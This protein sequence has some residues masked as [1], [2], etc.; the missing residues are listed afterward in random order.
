MAKRL[1][2]LFVYAIIIVVVKADGLSDFSNNLAS[3]LGPLLSLFGDAVTRQYLSESTKLIDYFIFAMAPIGIISTI[4]AVIRVCGSPSL[5]AFIGK[6][7]EGEATAE[8]E[9]CTST[10]SDVCELFNKGGIT[11]VLGRPDIIELVYVPGADGSDKS[12]PRLQL[13]TRYLE[14]NLDDSCWVKCQNESDSFRS[15]NADVDSINR[16][17]FAP[18][19]NLS[20]NVGIKR[21]PDSVFYIVAAIGFILQVGIIIFAAITAWP[22]G[23]NAQKLG[24]KASQNYAPGIYIVGTI[25]LCFG[26]W[27][28]AALIG[29]TTNEEYYERKDES[30]VLYWVQPGPQ[31]IGDQTFDS[32]AYSDADENRR[33][34]IWVSSVKDFDKTFQTPTFFAVL[35]VLLGYVAQ[36]IGLRGLDAWI[37]IAQLAITLIMSVLRGALRMRRLDKSDNRLQRWGNLVTGHELDWLAFEI[38]DKLSQ[39]RFWCLT[40][41]HDNAKTNGCIEENDDVLQNR[42]LLSNITGHSPF[43]SMEAKGFQ[44]W[45]DKRVKVRSKAKYL[46]EAISQAA[47]IL[48][49]DQR[50]KET[51]QLRVKVIVADTTPNWSKQ[52]VSIM[53]KPPTGPGQ[54][55]WTVD[56]SQLEAVLGL[57]LWS[58]IS[59]DESAK[60]SKVVRNTNVFRIVSACCES[61]GWDGAIDADM[62][63]WLGSSDLQYQKLS[64]DIE[65]GNHNY[66]LADGWISAQDGNF[67]NDQGGKEKFIN[68]GDPKAEN[69]TRFVNRKSNTSNTPLHK[70]CG[71]N[72]IYDALKSG[73]S[74]ENRVNVQGYWID[75]REHSLL[76]VCAQDLFISLLNSMKALGFRKMDKVAIAGPGSE[77]RPVNPIISAL[78]SC[79]VDNELGTYSHAISC[80]I[81]LLRSELHSY[82]KKLPSALMQEVTKYRLDEEWNSAETILRGLCQYFH[83]LNQANMD[84]TMSFMKTLKELGELYRWSLAMRSK[85]RHNF[86]TQGI[87]WMVEEF[88]KTNSVV[89]LYD[90]MSQMSLKIDAF[91]FLKM[92]DDPD[93]QDLAGRTAVSYCAEWGLLAHLHRYIDAG[94]NLDLADRYDL[95]PL[96]YAVKCGRQDAVRLLLGNEQVNVNRKM[97]NGRSALWLAA[98]QTN[99]SMMEELLDNGAH[100][101][102]HDDDGVTPLLLSV[103]KGHQAAIKMLMKRKRGASFNVWDGQRVTPFIW[104]AWKGYKDIAW[105]LLQKIERDTEGL[106]SLPGD[107]KEDVR[108]LL[109]QYPRMYPLLYHRDGVSSTLDIRPPSIFT[110]EDNQRIH[111]EPPYPEPPRLMIGISDLKMRCLSGAD[112]RWQPN[113][114]SSMG[115]NLTRTGYDRERFR[116]GY[117]EVHSARAIWLEIEAIEQE[118]QGTNIETKHICLLSSQRTSN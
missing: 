46:G 47:T 25:V 113:K 43:A 72:L 63:L 88:G 5:R 68:I 16:V 48:L 112:I 74:T 4:T 109:R 67:T 28:C 69:I 91:G 97:Y 95:T 81:P 8:A 10:S 51:I 29:R 103:K 58:I 30:S 102:I 9:L 18:K 89:T 118:F 71:W 92:R 65:P 32:F 106:E 73:S 14:D 57:W 26:V 101:D 42:V 105:L 53:M 66:S 36:F 33:L 12:K 15:N 87:R 70:F 76:D 94:A 90:Q 38:P 17:D 99:I 49:L 40:G 84:E 98:E 19:P 59:N 83:R 22:L 79:F 37:S 107:L 45:E 93:S 100:I 1:G 13:F 80:V 7:Q 104:A 23:W 31:V 50:I 54:I 110:T 114:V 61:Q 24:S 62:G 39:K 55:N 111:F 34:K 6:A 86:G 77:V 21:R 35:F 117:K 78:V 60:S 75:S 20:L 27:S 56:S 108:E 96:A 64:L 82:Y 11:R 116:K 52:I 41:E 85:E 44:A 115:F 3:D 2:F